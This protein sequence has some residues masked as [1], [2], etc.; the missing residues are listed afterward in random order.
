MAK[1]TQTLKP[2]Y[3]NLK[4]CKVD[5][6]LTYKLPQL[7]STSLEP[8]HHSE[9]PELSKKKFKSDHF[10]KAFLLRALLDNFK[11]N[12]VIDFLDP[13]KTR[14]KAEKRSASEQPT[15]VLDSKIPSTRLPPGLLTSLGVEF[16]LVSREEIKS[17][18][19][20]M[21]VYESISLVQY[22]TGEFRCVI[23]FL[24]QIM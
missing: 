23:L 16:K 12:T 7:D 21:E 8:S 13:A 14:K 2:F 19:F 3:F 24:V 11:L 6:V 9:L 17:M 20:S 10:T 22:K 5:N 1:L 4:T 18:L 15:D